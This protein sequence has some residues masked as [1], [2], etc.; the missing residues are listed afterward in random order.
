MDN[1]LRIVVNDIIGVLRPI[2]DFRFV[3][4][5]QG[6]LTVDPQVENFP[7]ALVDIANVRYTSKSG[8]SQTAE[9]V[10]TVTVADMLTNPTVLGIPS[11]QQQGGSD[12][13]SLL[14]L[15]NV[16]L[17]GVRSGSYSPL[18]RES[19]QKIPQQGMVRQLV[20]SYRF[21][22]TDTPSVTPTGSQPV[23]VPPF[24]AIGK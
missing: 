8:L 13:F 9:G 2:A 7:C 5:N 18:V 20:L 21:A 22:F 16:A 15:V 10:I 12:I 19:L 1:I 14:Q 23:S 4:E 24:I 11:G 3:G 17:H 6:Q